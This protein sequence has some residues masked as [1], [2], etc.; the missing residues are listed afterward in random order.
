[1]FRFLC[2]V[3]PFIAA[4][5]LLAA[6]PAFKPQTI[7]DA[8]QVGYGLAIGDVDGDGK[9]DIMLADKKDI[10]WYHNPSWQKHIIASRLTLNDNVCIAA[11]DLDGDGKVEIAVGAN[12]NPGN[13]ISRVESG[14]IHYLIAPED[15]TKRWKPVRLPG[16]PTTHR[17]H[18]VTPKNTPAQLVVLPL[19]GIGNKGG[20]GDNGVRVFAYEFPSTA[21]DQP[22]SWRMML[23]DE[24]L[25]KTHNFD[26]SGQ[27]MVVGGTEGLKI[28]NPIHP[29]QAEHWIGEPNKPLNSGGVGE[30]RWGPYPKNHGSEDHRI[31]ATIEPMHG[32]AVVVYG[33][34]KARVVL[35]E[36]LSQGHALAC[37]QFLR[38]SDREQVVAGWR[39]PDSNE[40]VGI[41]IYVWAD[42]QWISHSV[43]DNTMACE[44]LK[45][46]DL[47]GDGR[48][49]IIAAGRASR[50]VVIYWNEN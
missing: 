48:L 45:V 37:G 49:D 50:N 26:V 44:D 41:R 46:A 12:W 47:N 22:G 4:P 35:D 20:A 2:S 19:H 21:V 3:L 40:K 1:M 11:K 25:H 34:D 32:N 13:T 28:L 5:A 17:M 43:D 14:S 38:N 27:E 23:L 8:I 18:W 33:P 29:L 10:V 42:D 24:S 30:V 15:R 9:A 6:P 7:D 16:D 39:N 31:F 36:S